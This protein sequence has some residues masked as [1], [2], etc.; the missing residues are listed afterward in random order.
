[1]DK[2]RFLYLTGRK[3]NVIITKNGK[4]VYPEEL[5]NY[6]NHSPYIAETM[7]WGCE[8][9]IDPDEMTV[10]A[11]VTLE[12]DEVEAAL[13]ADYT[14]QQAQDLIWEEVDRINEDLPLF[15]KI[16][17]VVVRED[18]FQKN[19]AQKIKR[20]VDENKEG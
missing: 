18:D 12:K 5:E 11:T 10:A 4:N 15:K 3:K 1:M 17:K 16:K 13:G 7:V 14:P 20:F 8:S 2:D 19:T 9:E 6:L